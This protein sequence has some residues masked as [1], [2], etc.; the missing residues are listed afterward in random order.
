[1]C[2]AHLTYRDIYEIFMYIKI[3]IC[4]YIPCTYIYVGHMYICGDTN[5][6]S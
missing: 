2:E 4:I 5:M 3:Y 1:M 6:K